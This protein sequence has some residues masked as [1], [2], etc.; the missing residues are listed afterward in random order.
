MTLKRLPVAIAL[1]AALAG[2][3]TLEQKLGEWKPSPRANMAV[4][5]AFYECQF[6]AEKA[7]PMGDLRRSGFEI[8]AIQDGIFRSCMRSKGF[9]YIAGNY[10]G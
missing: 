7:A 3:K 8:A 2:C 4:D 9:V 10:G 1:V 5:Q 6:E